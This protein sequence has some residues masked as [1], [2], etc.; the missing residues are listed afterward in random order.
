MNGEVAQLARNG[1]EET[2]KAP[3]P[4]MTT[5]TVRRMIFRSFHKLQF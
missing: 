5:L 1:S 3:F 2:Y 4:V